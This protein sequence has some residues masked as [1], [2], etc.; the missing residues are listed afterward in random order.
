MLLRD[1]ADLSQQKLAVWDGLAARSKAPDPMSCA[2]AWQITALACSRR[3]GAQILLRQSGDSQVVVAAIPTF[4]GLLL[5]P[6]EAHWSFGCPLIGPDAVKMLAD[7]IE[8]LRKAR[9]GERISCSIP[10]L[11]PKGPLARQIEETFSGV[12]NR[13]QDSHAAASLAGGIEG[14]L[15]RR[16]G[17][18]R[19][20]LRRA[21]RCATDA[22]IHFERIQ[23]RSAMDADLTY[24][25]MLQ[26]EKES[27]KG[28]K[29]SGLFA[30]ERFYCL[31]L[32]A[33]AERDA[34]RIIIA[35][36][37]PTDVGFCYG[38]F[39]GS[40]YRGQQTSYSEH[41]A[42]LSVGT[43]MHYET[44][45]WL[46]EEEAHLHHFGPVQRNMSYKARLCEITL[47]SIEKSFQI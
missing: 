16:S 5:G 24:E 23:P 33:Y 4:D 18:T 41:V 31:L 15:S 1:P 8:E 34:A 7:M 2:S 37:G 35:R 43:L 44:V 29:S 6:L 21:Q 10:G 46:A 14:W 39:S 17:N 20:N 3:A 36:Q 30:L 40:I 27:W 11:D 25:R 13:R 28:Q 12:R 9:P 32:R 38:G 47:P 19:K 26:V 22:E 42:E 45:K